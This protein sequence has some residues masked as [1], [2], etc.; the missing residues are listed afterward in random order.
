MKPPTDSTPFQREV[1]SRFGLLPNFFSSA[2]DA[3]EMVEKLWE[4]AKSAYIE[5][6]IP[7]LFKERL[8]VYLSRFCEV[9]Y[10]ITRHCAFLVGYGHAAGDTTAP[11][12]SLADAIKLLTK[13]TPWQRT[14]EDWLRALESSP[15]GSDWPEP[16]TDFEDQLIAAAAFAFVEGRRSDRARHALRHALGGRRYEHL[17]G[18]VAFI[19]TAHYWTVLHPDLAPEE[20]IQPL[21]EANTELARLLL[22]DAEASRCDI[23]TQLYAEL[24][25]LRNLNER[26]KLE[27]A[28]QALAHEVAQ[29]EFLLKEVNHRVKN[30][31]Q[32]VSSILYLEIGNLKNTPAAESMRNAASR[33]MAVAAVHERL[34]TGSDLQTIDLDAFLADL[35]GN[36]GQAAWLRGWH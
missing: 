1:M 18:L 30:S 25:A 15:A 35:C 20:D 9:R 16:D 34:Y 28:N 13:P 8:F 36:M 11:A 10:C 17:L 19:R 31:L 5:N 32:I 3:P 2:P 14:N 22:D 23:G 27:L 6:P 7:S 4:F 33:V 21:L 24:E 29:K 12:Q 26:R